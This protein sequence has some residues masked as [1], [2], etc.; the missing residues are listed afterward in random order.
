L[1]E[2]LRQAMLRARL[3]EGDVAARLG[4]DPKTVRRWLSGR[5]PYPSS[6]AALADLVGVDEADLWPDA[7]GPLA[8]RSRP[9]ELAAVYPH[10]WAIPRD[11][12]TRF[13]ES[14][15]HEIG[16]LAYSAL[17]LAE[18]AGLLGII[19]DKASRGV[20]VRIALGEPD[21]PAV[22]RRGQEEGIGDAMAAKV[23]N[24]LALFRPLTGIEHIEIR[25]HEAIL[26]NSIYCADG[27][28]FVNQHAYGIAAARSPVFCYRESESGEIAAGYIDS[29]ERVWMLA[30]SMQ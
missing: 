22:A 21:C 4:V 12:W 9:E 23:R 15:E 7:G 29:F 1:N 25:L 27:Q 5:V 13:F 11:V 26:Y 28:L 30:K 24:A 17:F 20:R 2:S 19:A 10:R 14:A 16:V 6:R 18:D 8:G 3:R